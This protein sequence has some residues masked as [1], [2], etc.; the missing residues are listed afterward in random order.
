MIKA[1]RTSLIAATASIAIVS[2]AM[3]GGYVGIDQTG[4]YNLTKVTQ[5]R[6]QTRIV[7]RDLTPTTYL[8]TTIRLNA[9]ALRPMRG[10]ASGIGNRG[11][12][13]GVAG[14]N[15]INLAQTGENNAA[16]VSQQGEGFIADINQDGDHNIAV[17]KQRC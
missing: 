16:Y 11:C 1:F 13:I 9:K 4:S 2:S 8:R 3:A 5:K 17:V 7:Q 10:A 12:A 14:A 6:D 15:E